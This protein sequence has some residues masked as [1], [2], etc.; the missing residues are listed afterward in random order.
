MRRAGC[1]RCVAGT[2]RPRSRDSSAAAP[3]AHESAPRGADG[4]SDMTAVEERLGRLRRSLAASGLDAM[5]V[6]ALPNVRYLT[7]FS[8][9]N[10][11][12][13]VT[14]TDC[15]LLTDFR[16]ATQVKLEV[17]PAVRVAIE[18]AS[19]WIRLWKEL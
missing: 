11:L 16:Y 1:C 19:L 3:R 6:S 13:V 9:S 2:T 4:R 18:G 12:A 17:D 8:G 10:A 14:H 7:G 15:V 5:L